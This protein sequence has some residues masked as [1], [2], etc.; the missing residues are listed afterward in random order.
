MGENK[1][2]NPTMEI[3]LPTQERLQAMYSVLTSNIISQFSD[4]FTRLREGLTKSIFLELR[5]ITNREEL[6]T[7]LS[8]RYDKGLESI[9]YTSDKVVI[10]S[11]LA[12]FH[13]DLTYYTVEN[14]WNDKGEVLVKERDGLNTF[15][16]H[17]SELI[18]DLEVVKIKTLL[19]NK[20]ERDFIASKLSIIENE[21]RR[22]SDE[23][24]K[25]LKQ[26]LLGL[27]SRLKMKRVVNET[28]SNIDHLFHDFLISDILRANTS[29]QVTPKVGDIVWGYYSALS[30][31]HYY[32]PFKVTKIDEYR[33]YGVSDN[34]GIIKSKLTF[35]PF[36]FYPEVINT[37][38]RIEKGLKRELLSGLIERLK[39]TPRLVRNFL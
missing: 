7:F 28:L 24:K 26:V 36:S 1:R 27:L 4:S 34:V 5:G 12:N 33:I 21:K 32:H 38:Q 2:Y 19:Q 13:E 25:S 31:G 15:F 11:D 22:L 10:I 14:E 39:T 30:Y 9:P 16:I 18:T 29:K 35:Y 37:A 3:I 8:L 20:L 17:P 23:A 6:T